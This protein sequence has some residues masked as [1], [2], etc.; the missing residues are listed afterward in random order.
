MLSSGTLEGAGGA[1]CASIGRFTDP[2]V[3]EYPAAV[4][5]SCPGGNEM[6]GETARGPLSQSRRIRLAS[7]SMR[8]DPLDVPGR[9]GKRA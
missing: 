4:T 3:G 9:R 2:S 6:L 1:A 5:G 7:A 8:H